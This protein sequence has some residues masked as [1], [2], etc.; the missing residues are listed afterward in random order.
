MHELSKVLDMV[1]EACAKGLHGVHKS[2]VKGFRGISK[3]C[4]NGILKTLQT[5]DFEFL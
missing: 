2:C 5:R 1:S 3:A 4:E